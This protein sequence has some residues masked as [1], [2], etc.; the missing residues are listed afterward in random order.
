MAPLIL[1]CCPLCI[2][3]IFSNTI[4]FAI[5]ICSSFL[6]DSSSVGMSSTYKLFTAA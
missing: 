5:N 6:S 3:A 4:R 1:L 2:T